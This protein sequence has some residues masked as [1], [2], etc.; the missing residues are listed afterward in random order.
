MGA[1]WR[2]GPVRGRPSNARRCAVGFV[3]RW[4]LDY[5]C[6]LP[7]L[8]EVRTARF[9]GA[10]V[11]LNPW[12][13]EALLLA[14]RPLSPISPPGHTTPLPRKTM[15]GRA[16][17]ISQW[18]YSRCGSRSQSA[19]SAGRQ[20]D[21][22]GRAIQAQIREGNGPFFNSLG[23]PAVRPASAGWRRKPRTHQHRGA[24]HAGA[25]RILKRKRVNGRSSTG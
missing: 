19:A 6:A 23:L 13:D 15:I 14:G 11:N 4:V 21:L 25:S 18:A 8:V 9:P 22:A 17:A 3:T 10:G 12:L 2:I 20:P 16:I 24:D 7:R 5:L 1:C